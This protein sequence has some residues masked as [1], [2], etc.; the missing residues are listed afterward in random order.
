MGEVPTRPSGW[1]SWYHYYANVSAADIRENL[2]VRAERFPA[3]RYVQI[4]DGYQ[5]RMGDWLTPSAK[6]EEGVAALA[7]EIRAAG[8]EPAL[9]VAPFIAEP[10]S[11]SRITLTGS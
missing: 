6:F 3:L 1:C 2:A 5:A 9:W 4:D 11:C 8:C 10:G 7:G